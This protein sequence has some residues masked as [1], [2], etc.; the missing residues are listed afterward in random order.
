MMKVD[1][2]APLDPRALNVEPGIPKALECKM[3]Q[4]S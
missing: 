4:N 1:T 3:P 2:C